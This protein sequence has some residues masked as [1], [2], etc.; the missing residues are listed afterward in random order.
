[1]AVRSIRRA[2]G[3]LTLLAAPLAANAT[4]ITY[5]FT[6]GVSSATG[7]L[8]SLFDNLITGTMTFDLDNAN[9]ALSSG[10]IGTYPFQSGWTSVEHSGSA[11]QLAPSGDYVF[12]MTASLG[13]TLLYS[14]GAPGTYSSQSSIEGSVGQVYTATETQADDPTG[15]NSR[16]S[17]FS[18]TGQPPISVYDASGLPNI[19]APGFLSGSFSIEQ[20]GVSS[21]VDLGI[22]G[23]AP[24]PVPLPAAAWLLV[25]G[26]AG[27]GGF[28]RRVIRR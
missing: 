8:S 20:N 13:S 5:D 25:S 27:L 19:S 15:R 6:A 14:T 18:F 9:P 22:F 7:S 2:L 23:L 1:M 3:V 17:A 21:T 16:T 26:L 4:S 12:S 28:A 11:F 24:A 10:A